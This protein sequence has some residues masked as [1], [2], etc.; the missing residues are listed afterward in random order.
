VAEEL[1]KELPSLSTFVTLSPVPGFAAWLDRHLAQES[2]AGL[3]RE[4]RDTL[5]D[6]ADPDRAADPARAAALDRALLPAAAYYFLRAKTPGGRP[7]DP[8]ARFHLGN[9]ARLERLNPGG[10]L[11]PKGLRQSR[12]LMVNYLYD[13]DAIERNHEAYAESGAVAASGAV[14][15]A[16]RADAGRAAAPM[17]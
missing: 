2:P 7:L 14:T 13:L 5:R 1:K 4:Q 12:G 6:L 3:T 11:S 16:L 8:V 17:A 9:G 15:R 10:D